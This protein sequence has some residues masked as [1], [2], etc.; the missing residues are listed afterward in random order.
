M[1]EVTILTCHYSGIHVG[2]SNDTC[3]YRIMYVRY[4]NDTCHYP[5]IHGRHSNDTCT[6]VGRIVVTVNS[7]AELT[8]DVRATWWCG[9][10][11]F[12]WAG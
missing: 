12:P 3:K 1:I 10:M 2:Y 7:G 8:T 6:V 4:K 9:M 5:R 11:T